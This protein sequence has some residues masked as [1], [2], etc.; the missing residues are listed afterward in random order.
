MPRDGSGQYSRT[1]GS[2]TGGTVFAQQASANVGPPL[3]P[4]FDAHAN[5]MAAALTD[6]VAKDGQ[7]PMTGDLAMNT[8][9]ITGVSDATAA[10][11]AVNKGQLDVAMTA[12]PFQALAFAAV[13]DWD[14]AATRNGLLTMT[15]DITSFSVSNDTDGGAY[16]MRIAQD[17]TGGRT[18]AWPAAWLWP[19]GGPADLTAAANAIDMVAVRRIGADIYAVLVQEWATL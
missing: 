6:S 4:L 19:G 8:H 7:T 2:R 17:G 3:A 15:G 1:D 13:L 12:T 9:K 18:I 11:D 14:V 16:T 10:T 5:D